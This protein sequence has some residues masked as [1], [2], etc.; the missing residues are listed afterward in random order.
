MARLLYTLLFHALLPLVLMRVALR[1]LRAPGYGRRLGERFGRFRGAPPPGGIWLH[2]VSVGEVQ[3]AL[4]LVRALRRQYPELALTV[5]TMTPT[6]SARVRELFAD[7]VFHVYAPWDLPWAVAAFLRRTRPR[8][9]IVMETELWPNVI[10]ACRHRGLPVLLANAR[11]SRRS[12]RGYARIGALSRPMLG[13]LSA[14]AAQARE[15]ARRL[16]ALGVPAERL[17]VTGSIKF[18]VQV[19]AALRQRAAR[20]RAD[21]GARPVWIAASTHEGEEDILLNAQR[22]LQQDAPDALL[23]LVP[24]HPERFERVAALV[25]AAGFVCSRRS[26]AGPVTARTEVLLGD[27]MG[28][29][30]LLFGA[31]DMAFVG[32]SLVPRGGHNPLEPAAWGLPVL[33]GPSDFN[34]REINRLLREAGA[35]RIC[36][37]AVAIA[38]SLAGGFREPQSRLEAGAA[39]QRV[40][41]ANRGALQRLVAMTGALLADAQLSKSR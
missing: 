11:L 6:G 16:L 29:L 9:V 24:R 35:L 12:A 36:E 1:A 22:R 28:E 21:L 10:H 27:T 5:T 34:F 14:V 30:L 25:A 4:P 3:A 7:D 38:D 37:G 40:V 8:L 31:A 23:I 13:A 41:A 15:D 39:A 17:Q 32:G 2:A 26:V 19:D 18:D 33:A 20:L